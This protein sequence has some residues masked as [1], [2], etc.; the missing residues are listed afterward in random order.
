M[1]TKL[2]TE[3]LFKHKIFFFFF[4][5]SAHDQTMEQVSQ[6]CCGVF[7]LEDVRN[8][9]V[10]VFSMYMCLLGVHALPLCVGAGRNSSHICQKRKGCHVKG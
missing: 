8:L 6:R 5:Y 4:F 10:C 2:N 3:S 9:I 1:G 7:M